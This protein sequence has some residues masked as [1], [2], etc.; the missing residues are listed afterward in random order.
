MPVKVRPL[1][2]IEDGI[3]IAIRC[4]ALKQKPLA[5]GAY[6]LA[7]SWIRL[8]QN[9]MPTELLKVIGVTE[10]NAIVRADIKAGSDRRIGEKPA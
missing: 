2:E 10:G 1:M 9:T 3:P 4:G 6:L 5:A 7:Q 8:Y